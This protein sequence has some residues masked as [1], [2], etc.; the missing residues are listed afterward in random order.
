MIKKNHKALN[1]VP[2]GLRGQITM[3]VLLRILWNIILG[4]L[5]LGEAIRF[6]VHHFK[7][8]KGRIFRRSEEKWNLS[9]PEKRALHRFLMWGA[10]DVAGN[11]FLLGAEFFAEVIITYL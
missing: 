9:H 4:I 5:I 2:Y 1:I 8:L 7:R 6:D 10:V 3:W 11:V